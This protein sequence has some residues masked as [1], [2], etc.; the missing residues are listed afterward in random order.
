MLLALVIGN[1]EIRLGFLNSGVLSDTAALKS[2]P[3]RTA[4]EY[5]C[6][7]KAILDLRGL[8][9][10]DID[11]AI[12][13]SVVPALT[14]PVRRAVQTLT[15]HRPHLLGAGMKTGLD[16]RTDDPSQLGGDLV[17][18]AI[19]ALTI[20]KPPM[21][22]IDLGTA[23]TFS[24]IG[25]DG[26]FLG[27]AIAPGVALSAKALSEGASLLPGLTREVPKKCIGT[28][29]MESMQSGCLHGSAAM[30]DGMIDRIRAEMGCQDAL[31]I[32]SGA[33]AEAL[34]PLCRREIRCD[35]T[36]IFRG[37]AEIY[38]KNQRRR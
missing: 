24:V 33:P 29:T 19:G 7:I 17:S 26:A 4:D 23:T 34:I 3:S 31:V 16:I 14:E 8:C 2:D 27:C 32:A 6:T 25:A 15:G 10:S 37:L 18:S 21:I 13:A 38:R 12:C 22:L 11:G 35:D 9:A 28:N 36:L 30:L 5:A 20:C 1:S